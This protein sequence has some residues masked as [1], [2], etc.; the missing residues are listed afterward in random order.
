ML[1]EVITR[2][3]GRPPAGGYEEVIELGRYRAEGWEYSQRLLLVI[4]DKPDPRTGVITSYSIH[5]TKL[6]DS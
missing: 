5:Y 2:R 4:V 1:Y 6:Y 3:P